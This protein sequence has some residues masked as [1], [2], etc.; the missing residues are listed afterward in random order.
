MVAS[1]VAGIAQSAAFQSI[2]R[3]TVDWYQ[4]FTWLLIAAIGLISAI[5]YTWV[6]F[7]AKAEGI[8]EGNPPEIERRLSIEVA[9]A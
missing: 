5:A 2:Y 1:K 6:Y 3:A 9:K 8:G 7:K 4:G